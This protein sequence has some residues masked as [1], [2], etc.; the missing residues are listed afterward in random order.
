[1]DRVNVK[2]SETKQQET[3]PPSKSAPAPVKPAGGWTFKDWAAI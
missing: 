3:E 1:M 2:K